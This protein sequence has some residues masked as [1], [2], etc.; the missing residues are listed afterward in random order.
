MGHSTLYNQHRE[1]FFRVCDAVG[2]NQVEQVRSLLE[3]T[4]LLSTLRRYN[5]YDGE[6]LLHLAAVSGSREVCALLVSLGMDIDLPL[7]GYRNHTPLSEAAGHGH[8]DTCRW[9]LDHGAAVDGLPDNILSPLDS[10]CVDGHQDVVALLL[11]RGANPNR[12]HTRWNQAPVDIAAGWGFPAIVQMLATAGGVSIL[13]VPQQAAASPQ[14][15]IRTFMHHSAG[16][17]LPAVFSPD[18]GDARFSLG[19]SCIGG[20]REFKLLFTAGLFQQ[21][22]M[23]ELAVCLPARW[24]LT[25][26][27]FAE[28][29]PWRFP[30]ALLARLGRRTLDQASLAAGELLRRDDPYLA[31]LAWPEGVDALLAID[32]RWNPEPEEDDVADDDKVTIYLLVPVA[33]TKKGAPGASTLPALMERKLKGSWKVSALPF[34]IPR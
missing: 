31:D 2:E 13:D 16:W 29:S 5:M 18:S 14:D 12:L 23:T 32:K 21:S 1:A 20:K 7:P 28:H 11:Q 17:V 6:S 26:H 9:L 10:A 27:G 4:P 24:P 19:I 3:A 33:Y 30:V 25:V 34:A 22:P 8:V 15:V